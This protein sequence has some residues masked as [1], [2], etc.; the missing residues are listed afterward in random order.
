MESSLAYLIGGG[1]A[2]L[3][4]AAFLIRDGHVPGSMI[5]ILEESDVTGGSLDAHGSPE[6]GYVMRGGRMFTDDTYE[7]TWALL[8]S[9]PSLHDPQKTVRQE[10]IAFNRE[11]KSY[12]PPRRRREKGRSLFSRLQL[13]GPPRPRETDGDSGVV[14]GIDS[15]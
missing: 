8:S 1:I 12:S 14:S 3:A 4:A 2:S 15:D 9:I 5:Q 11:I 6:T 13:E 7:C 10:I